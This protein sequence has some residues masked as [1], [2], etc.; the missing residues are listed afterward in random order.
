MAHP[1]QLCPELQI[2]GPGVATSLKVANNCCNFHRNCKAGLQ[3]YYKLQRD[4][5]TLIEVAP[6]PRIFNFVAALTPTIAHAG[7][8]VEASEGS[9][10]V[11]S[12][13]GHRILSCPWVPHQ[14]T[15]PSAL[16]LRPTGGLDRPAAVPLQPE[17]PG[18]PQEKYPRGSL[19]GPNGSQ[20]ETWP[21]H[22]DPASR[23]KDPGS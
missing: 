10:P 23:I 17:R 6:A 13:W 4:V 21:L 19:L 9:I 22:P 12:A 2:F 1:L 14:G 20:V 15:R 8:L 7:A 3:L 11:A 16:H 5:A 18:E